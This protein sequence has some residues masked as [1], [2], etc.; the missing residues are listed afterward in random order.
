VLLVNVDRSESIVDEDL[1]QP[2]EHDCEGDGTGRG[3]CER[4]LGGL[5]NESNN[6][7][8]PARGRPSDG[9]SEAK[10][11]EEVMAKRK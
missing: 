2:A 1:K 11:E 3:S 4:I 8:A 6:T 9:S 7:L 10:E 5:G